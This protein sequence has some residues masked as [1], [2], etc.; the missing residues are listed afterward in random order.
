MLSGM[1][2]VLDMRNMHLLKTHPRSD[3]YRISHVVLTMSETVVDQ[4]TSLGALHLTMRVIYCFIP[5]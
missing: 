5:C 1:A 4:L 2:I 3:Y